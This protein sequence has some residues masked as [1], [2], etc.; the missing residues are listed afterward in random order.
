MLITAI[1]NNSFDENI[2]L[3]VEVIDCLDMY[4]LVCAYTYT[5]CVLD[6]TGS[7]VSNYNS[8]LNPVE[9]VDGAEKKTETDAGW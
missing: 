6:E 3:H 4:I 8:H 7:C 2:F 9:D 5:M 1:T